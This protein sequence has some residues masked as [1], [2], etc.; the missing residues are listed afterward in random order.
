MSLLLVRE[1][2]SKQ[3]KQLR[4]TIFGPTTIHL[5]HEFYL[6]I[7]MILLE[8][9]SLQALYKHDSFGSI[10]GDYQFT[11]LVA[12]WLSRFLLLRWLTTW[13]FST[14]RRPTMAGVWNHWI[15]SH[16]MAGQ[17]FDRP[18]PSVLA[19][20]I[21]TQHHHQT[22]HHHH[23]H[24]SFDYSRNGMYTFHDLLW[25]SL[26]FT[27]QYFKVWCWYPL[28]SLHE[29]AMH[30]GPMTSRQ[31]HQQL[32]RKLSNR[33]SGGGS[34]GGGTTSGEGTR[35]SLSSSSVSPM[36]SPAYYTTYLNK[37]WRTYGP[38]LQMIIPIATV[39]FIL[40]YGL[41]A[42][43]SEES[44]HALTMQTQTASGGTL[45]AAN[46]ATPTII[47]Y[48]AAS[49]PNAPI[50]RPYGA[51]KKMKPPTW[52]EVLYYLSCGGTLLSVL[53][54]GRIVLPIPDLV[55]GSNVLKA[56]RNESKQQHQQQQTSGGSSI[57][58]S[59]GREATLR[60]HAQGFSIPYAIQ[61]I[62]L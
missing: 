20:H 60:V 28:L 57:G 5:Q 40:W 32:L 31:R 54:Y 2:L 55:A 6:W 16:V 11:A 4:Y 51:Y 27:W 61:L 48:S 1:W 37:L 25:P 12:L 50:N 3:S 10:R 24:H 23:Y 29:R 58:V 30:R 62:V 14:S 26:L 21:G 46:Y 22:H 8:L 36:T 35:H 52:T 45:N 13:D 34:S 33:R 43:A 49:N 18:S 41:W 39:L 17:Y 53:L 7:A 19:K 9:S 42:D 38:S 56:L 59:T 44:P 47:D 15:A